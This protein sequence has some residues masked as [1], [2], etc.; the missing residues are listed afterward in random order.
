MGIPR[1][2]RHLQPYSVLSALNSQTAIIDGPAL[3]YYIH[4]LCAKQDNTIPSCQVLG[5]TVL[6]WLERLDSYNITV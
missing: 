3:A 5:T 2:R 1:L 4:R 6:R